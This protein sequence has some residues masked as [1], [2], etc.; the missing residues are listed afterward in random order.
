MVP[1]V[2]EGLRADDKGRGEDA[3]EDTQAKSGL[4]RQEMACNTMQR[5]NGGLRV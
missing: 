1:Y 4:Q 3:L 5:K 2:G